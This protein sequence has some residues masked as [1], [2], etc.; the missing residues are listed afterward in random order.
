MGF[1]DGIEKESAA[2][3]FGAFLRSGHYLARI[4]RLRSGTSEKHSCDF[5]AV[6][7]TILHVFDD[8]QKPM[9]VN[10]DTGNCKDW[11][12]DPKGFHTPGEEASTQFLGKH[13]SSKRNFKA[14]VAR[15]VGVDAEQ[16]DAAFCG[17]VEQNELLNGE[18]VEMNNRMIEKKDG[19]PITKI[20][21]VRPVPASEF[22]KIL[23]PKIAKRFFPDGFQALIEAESEDD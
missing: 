21:V 5:A 23:E 7:V 17:Q 10:P 2:K 3:D 15:A 1:Y 12:D 11:V 18:V 19:G 14:F 16:I 8:G 22:S 20:W 13:K 4:N 9:I 6:D